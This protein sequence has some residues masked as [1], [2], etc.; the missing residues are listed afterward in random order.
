MKKMKQ[1]S[2]TYLLLV[3]LMSS[4]NMSENKQIKQAIRYQL[5][6]YPASRLTDIYKSFFQDFYGPGHL[7]ENPEGALNYLERELSE[8][9]GCSLKQP[10]ELTGYR[11]RFARVDLCLVTQG[12][13]SLEDFSRLFIES[14]KSFQ[15]PDIDEWKAEWSKILDVI[16][17]M[18]LEIVGFE[19]DKME[20]EVMLEKGDYVVHHSE[21]FIQEYGPH[22][23]IIRRDLLEYIDY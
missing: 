16:D 9:T 5:E 17:G 11:S 13:I 6:N 21:G 7:L 22:Y 1:L 4:C 18:N 12:K 20:L 19:S 3:V 14:G 15:L 2:T 23:R 10:V 8:V